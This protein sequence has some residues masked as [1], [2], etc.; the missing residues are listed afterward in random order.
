MQKGRSQWK[1]PF[2]LVP[3]YALVPECESD[4]SAE[5]ISHDSRSGLERGFDLR[6]IFTTRLGDFRLAAS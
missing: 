4:A 5:Q 3:A 1:R 2:L 6:L